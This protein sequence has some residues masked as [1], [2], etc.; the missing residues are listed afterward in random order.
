MSKKLTSCS[1]WPSS[2]SSHGGTGK[3]ALW[4]VF[5]K[6]ANPMDEDSS[7]VSISTCEFVEGHDYSVHNL[8]NWPE[9]PVLEDVIWFTW[10]LSAS[11]VAT[12]FV[13][14][15]CPILC[16]PM[17]C[18]PPGSSAH[19]ILQA[20]ILEWVAISFSRDLP[21][22]G[23]EPK[24]PALQADYLPSKPPGRSTPR[25]DSKSYL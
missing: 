23:I 18:S 3:R 19:G 21:N 6:G 4:D 24:S 10:H 15:S 14:Q 17:D 25:M 7:K 8:P 13:T 11:S 22:P 1:R 5:N 12:C 20:Q 2:V 16:N 9:K